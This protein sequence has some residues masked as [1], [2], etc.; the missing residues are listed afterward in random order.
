MKTFTYRTR[1]YFKDTDAGGVVYHGN[2]VYLCERA[3]THWHMEIAPQYSNKKLMEAGQV[4]VVAAFE[5]QYKRPALLDDE[6]DIVCSV[7]E[8][9]A[10]FGTFRQEFKRG[11]ETLAIAKVKVTIVNKETGRPVRFPLDMKEAY[12]EYMYEGEDK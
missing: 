11:D 5:I 12:A 9:G 4:F 10:A 8:L 7:V 3:R 6:I 2:Y 1:I